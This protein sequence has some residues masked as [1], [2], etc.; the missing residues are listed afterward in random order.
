MVAAGAGRRFG[1]AK[2]YQALAGRR[3]LDWSL[4]AARAIA[5]GV[6]VVVAPDRVGDDERLPVSSVHGC[7]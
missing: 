3:V 6:V 4:D 2:Q 7:A 5:D 1:G